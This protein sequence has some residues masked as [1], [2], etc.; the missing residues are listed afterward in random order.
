[1]HR[2]SRNA[3]QAGRVRSFD[4]VR[5]GSREAG[6]W[7]AYYRHEWWRFLRCAVGMVRTGF[8]M[9]WPRTLLGAWF[10]LRANQKWA[11]YPDNDPDAARRL[12]H[13]FY[14]QVTRATGERFDIAEAAR[15]EVAWW[16]AHRELQRERPGS[17]DEELVDALAALYAHVY[18]IP[19]ADGRQAG[20]LRAEAMRLSDTWV[21]AGCDPTSPLVDGERVAL[22]RSYATLL[23][24]V[25]R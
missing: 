5:L 20:R 2:C 21:E 6:A 24:A 18:G 3:C 11:P 10:V 12:M 22:V 7:V 9:S 4:P 14:R 23:A 16:R 19:A 25:Y 15:L 13:R 8:G 17:G 1:M